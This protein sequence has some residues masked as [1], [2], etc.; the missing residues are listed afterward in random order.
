M[1]YVYFVYRVVVWQPVICMVCILC[2]G[3]AA[4][5]KYVACIVLWCGSVS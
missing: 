3:V 1:S 2:G 5:Y 4:C